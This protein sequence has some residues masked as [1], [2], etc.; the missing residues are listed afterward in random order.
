[1]AVILKPFQNLLN[2]GNFQVPTGDLAIDW[3]N[4]LTNGLIG[5]YVPGVNYGIDVS[6][7]A[8]TLTP[9]PSASAPGTMTV[10]REGPGLLSNVAGNALQAVATPTFKT[11][12]EFSIYWRGYSLGDSGGGLGWLIGMTSS[13]TATGPFTIVAIDQNGAGANWTLIWNTGGTGPQSNVFTAAYP[14]GSF[15]AGG[16]FRVSAA[17]GTVLGYQNGALATSSSVAFGAAAPTSTASAQILLNG[18]PITGFNSRFA[19]AICYIGCFWNRV[20]SA[21]EMARLDREPYSFIIPAEYEMPILLA[22]PALRQKHF[23]FRTDT[24]AADATPTW[25]A[26]EDTN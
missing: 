20:L 11:W 13:N 21:E 5:C 6:C 9:D 3:T 7:Q 26:L 24:G 19:N 1:M 12:T 8:P 4:P 10:G 22:P 15:S 2:P 17:T 23:R 18:W 16:T 25:G 14:T